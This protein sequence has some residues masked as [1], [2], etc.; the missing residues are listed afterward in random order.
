MISRVLDASLMWRSDFRL[1]KSRRAIIAE[2]LFLLN[3]RTHHARA[4]AVPPRPFNSLL[5]LSKRNKINMSFGIPCILDSGALSALFD[6]IS[7]FHPD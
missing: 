2:L 4:I 5:S 3:S 6:G 1:Q 7:I